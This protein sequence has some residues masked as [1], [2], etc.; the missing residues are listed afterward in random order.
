MFQYPCDKK[1]NIMESK[2]FF[3]FYQWNVN[4]REFRLYGSST[5]QYGAYFYL[6]LKA[7]LGVSQVGQ[8]AINYVSSSIQVRF[9]FDFNRI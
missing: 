1:I 7:I 8:K 4:L 2:C 3:L 9:N 5:E 6:K